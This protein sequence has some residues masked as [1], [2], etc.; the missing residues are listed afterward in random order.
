MKGMIFAAGL[1]LRLRPLTDVTPKPLIPVKDIPLIAH[2]L[3]FLK[4][5]GVCEVVINL[6]H[7]AGKIIDALGDGRRFGLRIIYSR[8]ETLL[9]TGGGLKRAER[10]LGG[11]TFI[12]INSDIIADVDL[13]DVLSFHRENKA[14]ATMVLREDPEAESFGPIGVD[15]TGRIGRF[16]GLVP[17]APGR[18]LRTC[19]FTGIHVLDPGVFAYIPGE[20]YSSITEVMYPAL[21]RRGERVFGYVS[22]GYWTDI[23]TPDRYEKALKDVEAGKVKMFFGPAASRPDTA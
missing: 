21:L 14:L 16:L 17:P 8:E 3:H 19:M 20:G 1:G 15:R 4:R 18:D 11:G 9:G 23:G 5:H 10:H 12:L 22:T 13:G 6:H 7:H 2:T